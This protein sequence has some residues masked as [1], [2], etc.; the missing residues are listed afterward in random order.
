MT[1]ALA[2]EPLTVEEVRAYLGAPCEWGGMTERG[3]DRSGLVHMAYRRLGRLIPGDADQQE[4]AGEPVQ[5]ADVRRGDLVCYGATTSPSGW[6][7]G[8]SGTRRGARV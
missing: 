4:A 3:I 8:A 5:E 6:A 1:Q 7:T 2:G